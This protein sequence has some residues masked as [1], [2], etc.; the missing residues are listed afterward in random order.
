[1]PEELDD[2]A[3]ERKLFALAGYNP[4]GSKPLPERGYIHAELRPSRVTLAR[5]RTI[6]AGIIPKGSAT[7]GSATFTSNG[8]IGSPQRCGKPVRWAKSYS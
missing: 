2:A 6:T 4:P 7:A 8:A 1:V 3:L 5:L